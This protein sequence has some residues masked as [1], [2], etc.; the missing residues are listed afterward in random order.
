MKIESFDRI[1][2]FFFFFFDGFFS[3]F[4][5]SPL[6]LLIHCSTQQMQ[7]LLRAWTAT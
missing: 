7:E 1:D 4:V 3:S 2:F 6:S 5:F